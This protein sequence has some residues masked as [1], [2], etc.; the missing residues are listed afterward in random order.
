MN[1][2]ICNYKGKG[3]V[4]VNT[5]YGMYLAQSQRKRGAKCSSCRGMGQKSKLSY[6]HS[7]LGA[8]KVKKTRSVQAGSLFS[9]SSLFSGKGKRKTHSSFFLSSATFS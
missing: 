9:L 3:V 5:R 6:R 7:E 2:L 4:R 8:V 1:F